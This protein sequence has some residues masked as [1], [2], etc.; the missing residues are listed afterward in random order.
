LRDFI[1]EISLLT[2]LEEKTGESEDKINLM[3]VHASK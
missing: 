2:D 3:T 1:D